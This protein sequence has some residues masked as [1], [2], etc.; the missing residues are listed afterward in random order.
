MLALNFPSN[1]VCMILNRSMNIFGI[2]SLRRF[3]IHNSSFRG[4]EQYPNDTQSMLLFQNIFLLTAGSL[5][6]YTASSTACS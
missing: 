3:H 2:Y 5:D 6:T 1:C 4:G